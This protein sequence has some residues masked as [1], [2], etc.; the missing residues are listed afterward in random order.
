MRSVPPVGDCR[1]RGDEGEPAAGDGRSR[2]L[3]P[4]DRSRQHRFARHRSTG[5]RRSRPAS[6]HIRT[7]V[8]LRSADG[9]GPTSAGGA[10]VSHARPPR[11]RSGER[12]TTMKSRLVRI[13]LA[14]AAFGTL[15]Y[16]VGAPFT[17]PH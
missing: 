13:A 10:S 17:S 8:V 1:D 3:P 5:Y 2:R 11:E 16:T 15:V 7:K 4:F 12:R 6:A 9:P 14:L